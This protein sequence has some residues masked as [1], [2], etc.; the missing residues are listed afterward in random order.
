MDLGFVSTQFIHEQLLHIRK[1]TESEAH[2]A[3]L[4]STYF[5]KEFSFSSTKFKE[6][7]RGEELELADNV[8]WLDDLLLITQIKERNKSN[9]GNIENWFARKV[10]RK[11][12]KQIKDTIKYFE[13]YNDISIK[14]EKGHLLNVTEAIKNAPIKLIAYHC[15]ESLSEKNRFLKFYQSK[16][17][18][19]IH[20]FHIE[21]Y[22][23]ICNILITPFEIKDYLNFREL[24]YSR[25]KD[26]LNIY[27]EQY[28]LGHYIETTDV[29]EINPKYI[30]NLTNL[31]HDESDFDVSFI[32]ENFKEKIRLKPDKLE[33][34][35]II[36]EIAKLNR[37]DLRA[38]K[39]R[40]NFVIDKAK[41]QEFTL[42]TRMT[43]LNSNCGFIFTVLEYKQ[44]NRWKTALTNFIEAHKYDQ[45]L[46]KTIGMVVYFN[47]NDKYFDIN[48]G[49]VEFEWE[50]NK[51]FEELLKDNFPFRPVKKGLDYRYY[52]R[53]E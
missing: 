53:E 32:I 42:P 52:V 36:K 37:S 24:L 34:Y 33:Y 29:S 16:D 28:I 43:S 18:G 45:R 2:I 30:E 4:N 10:L 6:N 3:K 19:L 12:V 11:A 26:I 48:W 49:L 23:G 8:V 17:V 15:D 41:N 51:E 9:D 1:M 35:S 50:Y 40:F 21:D 46:N 7:N 31:V 20:L 38:F 25:H 5:F 44:K 13:K 22:N 14:N 27:P 39:E 47:P